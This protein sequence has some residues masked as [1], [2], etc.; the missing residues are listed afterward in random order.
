VRLDHAVQLLCDTSWSMPRIAAACGF[1]RPELMTRAFR[2]ELKTT[3]SEFR[4]RVS[5]D[6]QTVAAP[7]RG[8]ANGETAPS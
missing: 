5:R 7:V 6:R 3:P 4:R 8:L 2:R 1:D